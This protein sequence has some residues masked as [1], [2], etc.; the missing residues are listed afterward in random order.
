MLFLRSKDA[1]RKRRSVAAADWL[2]KHLEPNSS[3]VPVWNH[4]FDWE[5]RTP[6]KA[7]WYSGLAQGQGISLLVRIARETG[8]SEY[9][10]AATR[11]FVSF[12]K[13]TQDGGVVFTDATRRHL[14]RGVHRVATHS[15]LERLHLGCVG[16][17]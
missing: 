2:V 9:L 17:V 7:P 3:G 4:M 6:L 5:Y 13:S 15:Y 1:E 16:R 11:A 12:L 8:K 10:E 14:V